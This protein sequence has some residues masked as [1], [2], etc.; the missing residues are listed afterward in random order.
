MRLPII[1]VSFGELCDKFT[2]LRIKSEKIKDENKLLIIQR[3]I[4]YLKPFIDEIVIDDDIIN[5]L[6]EI[7]EKLWVIEDKIREKENKKEFDDEFIELARMVY[8]TNDERNKI[9]IT[10]DKILNSEISDIKS[11]TNYLL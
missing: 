6:K 9:K 3:E 5:E 7:N 10:I 11:Y 2:I 1:P 8:K 4:S